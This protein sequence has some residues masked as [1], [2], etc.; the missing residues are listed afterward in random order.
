MKKG[1]RRCIFNRRLTEWTHVM[2]KIE[3]R[4]FDDASI[5]NL[6]LNARVEVEIYMCNKKPHDLCV[7]V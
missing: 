4:Q 1:E 2:Y 6:Y 7:Y 5:S 3:K